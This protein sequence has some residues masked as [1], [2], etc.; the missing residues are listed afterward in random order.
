MHE[1]EGIINDTKVFR[2]IYPPYLVL[3]IDQS[4]R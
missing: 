4:Q 2:Y 1:L 3:Y